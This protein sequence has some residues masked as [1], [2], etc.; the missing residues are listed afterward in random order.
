MDEHL[1]ILAFGAH[2]DDVE[3]FC[4]GTLAK[5]A[6]RGD[7]VFMAA[8][9]N[10]DMGHK[11]IPPEK[12]A[13]IRHKEAQNSAGIIGATLIWPNI[14]GP[15]FMQDI[16]MRTTV[17]DVV[18]EANPDMVITHASYD[19]HPNHRILSEMVWEAVFNASVPHIQS[20]HPAINKFPALYHM[21]VVNGIHF[22]P[23]E[24]VDITDEFPTKIAMFSAHESQLV[25][26][27]DH[28]GKGALEQLEIHSRYRGYQCSTKYAEGFI[29]VMHSPLMT[30]KRMLP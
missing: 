1:R 26:M 13:T 12:L 18:R 10:G 9:S 7:T 28:E 6:K 27:H 14:S 11:T 15:H 5:C 29:R 2:P 8:L 25:W 16:K 17:M 19:Y 3:A 4:G 21:D 22:Q 23:T 30:C 24:Y 20:A